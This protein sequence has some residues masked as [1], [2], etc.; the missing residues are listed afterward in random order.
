MAQIEFKSFDVVSVGKIYAVMGAVVGLLYGILIAIFASLMSS[1]AGALGANMGGLAAMGVL[2]I[3]VAPITFAI[4]GFI[5]GLISAF[6]YNV[7]AGWV[8]GVKVNTA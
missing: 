7:V 4:M 3:I 6:I 5:G 2:A 8:G 1:L